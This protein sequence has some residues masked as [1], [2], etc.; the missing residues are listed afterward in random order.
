MGELHETLFINEIQ[1]SGIDLHLNEIEINGG[2]MWTSEFLQD[3]H[4][5]PTMAALSEPQNHT[6]WSVSQLNTINGGPA[7]IPEPS[8]IMLIGLGLAG[9]LGVRRVR[10]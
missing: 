6:G 5:T 8:T 1:L 9:L 3:Y 10:G 2:D 7:A 4:T